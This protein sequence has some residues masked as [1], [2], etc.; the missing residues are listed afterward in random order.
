[1]CSLNSPILGLETLVK[2]VRGWVQMGRKKYFFMLCAEKLTGTGATEAE[3]EGSKKE[4][5][6]L[7]TTGP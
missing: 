5:S 3:S 1:M 4:E 2:Q 7:W 6:H